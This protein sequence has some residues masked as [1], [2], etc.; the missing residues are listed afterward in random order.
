MTET[1]KLSFMMD[2][3]YDNLQQSKKTKN[4]LPKLVVH[5][6]NRKTYF[7]NYS[8]ICESLNRES[9]YFIKFLEKELN[10]ST[11][12]NASDQLLINGMYKEKQIE[13][14]VINFIESNVRCMACRSL[15]T[16]ISKENKNIFIIC[17]NC[18][19]RN[20]KK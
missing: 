14:I 1:Y 8:S 10:T 7:A 19:A 3:I 17:N 20:P 2:R 13:K 16:D 18:N 4:T 5:Y 6:E 15:N 9:N 11:S 12:V